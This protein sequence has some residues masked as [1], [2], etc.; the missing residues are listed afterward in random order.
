MSSKTNKTNNKNLSSVIKKK[1]KFKVAKLWCS[2]AWKIYIW[3]WNCWRQ[4]ISFSMCVRACVCAYMHICVSVCIQKHKGLICSL[5]DLETVSNL[6]C[7][8]VCSHTRTCLYQK[9]TLQTRKGTAHYKLCTPLCTVL[10]Q[11]QSLSDLLAAATAWAGQVLIRERERNNSTTV[12]WWS[13]QR[14]LHLTW[15]MAQCLLHLTWLTTSKT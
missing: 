9:W 10:A 11:W 7:M 2:F 8:C 15:L 5:P 14:Q 13:A 1:K 3:D 6:V 12:C 4:S